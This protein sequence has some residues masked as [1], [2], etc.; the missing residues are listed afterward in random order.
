M[1]RAMDRRRRH[2]VPRSERGVTLVEYVLFVGGFVLIAITAVGGM[3][4]TAR[5]YF[6]QSSNRIGQP[7]NR[8]KYDANG[9]RQQQASTTSITAPPSTTTTT[10]APTTTRA[11]TTTAAPTTT[12]ATTTTAAPTTT[13]TTP[14]TTTT[15]TTPPTTTI[16]KRVSTSIS[17]SSL[18]TANGTWTF[19]VTITVAGTGGA[20]VN[21]LTVSAV[22]KYGGTVVGTLSCVTSSSGVC[23]M[24]YPGVP[25]YYSPIVFEITSV[26]GAAPWTG[27]TKT[28]TVYDP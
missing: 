5:N 11:T 22:G 27:L 18:D 4:T 16:P 10:I 28:I 13:T 23:T 15:T 24:T 12:R 6:Q 21:G 20:S 2:T 8:V 14:P 7:V 25:D 26:S 9:N 17:N 19:R 3:N 1:S